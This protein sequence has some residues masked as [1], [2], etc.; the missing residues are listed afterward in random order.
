V[1]FLFWNCGGFPPS[2]E[3]P[4][5]QIIRQVINSYGPDIAAFAEVNISWKKAKPHDRLRE[6]TWGWFPNL[7]TISSYAQE[8]PASSPFLVGGTSIFT[9]N[10][11]VHLV[12]DSS[13]DKMGRW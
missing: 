8:F 13:W 9:M 4:K 2:R 7:H 5:N 12:V 11:C 6:R 1:R 3:H 10:E